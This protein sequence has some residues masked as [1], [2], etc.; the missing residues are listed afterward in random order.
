HQPGRPPHPPSATPSP[1]GRHTAA[2]P[3]PH[4]ANEQQREAARS[5]AGGV[6]LTSG[7]SATFWVYSARTNTRT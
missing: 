5:F 6:H 1:V 3:Q 4:P 2:A 7:K